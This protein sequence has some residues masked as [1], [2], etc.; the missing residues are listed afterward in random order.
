[1]SKG[2]DDVDSRTRFN[3]NQ[4]KKIQESRATEI[5]LELMERCMVGWALDRLLKLGKS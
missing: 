4:G 3:Q 1:M 2:D 5:D